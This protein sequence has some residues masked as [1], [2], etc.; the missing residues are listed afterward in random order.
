MN[1]SMI[2]LTRKSS[3]WIALALVAS[4]L[5]AAPFS[6]HASERSDRASCAKARPTA[7]ERKQIQAAYL[8]AEKVRVGLAAD[9]KLALLDEKQLLSSADATFDAAQAASAKTA[10]ARA[11]LGA[12]KDKLRNT[13]LYSILKP[14]NRGLAAK[15][16]ALGQS[17]ARR[18]S[19]GRRPSRDGGSGSSTD[20]GGSDAGN[21]D[22][23][24]AGDGLATN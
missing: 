8:D 3:P 13:I 20:A 5:G 11:K 1:R 14:E 21:P 2:V 10:D 4:A 7:D 6:A 15:C 24:D 18:N 23:G 16:F 22:A 9:L 12:V 19:R 17:D